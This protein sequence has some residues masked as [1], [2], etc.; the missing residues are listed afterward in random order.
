[1]SQLRFP[2]A[3]FPLLAALMFTPVA[4]WSAEVASAGSAGFYRIDPQT[5]EGLQQ[6]FKPI[7]QPL[8]FLSS[9]R[10]GAGKG[11]PENCIA[12]FE[13]TIRHTYSALEIDL[14]L[15]S[16]GTIVLNHDATLDRTTTGK[17]PVAA[18]TLAELKQLRL[19]DREGAVTD[20]Q[21]PTLDEAITWA[22]GKT[23]LIL[24][25]KDV[26]LEKR[27][28][29]VEEHKAESYVMLMLYSFKEIETCHAR[30]PKIM[31]EVMIGDMER[32]RGFD[33]TGVP[34][35]SVVAFIS[36]DPP[37]AT[38][39]YDEIHQRGASCMVGT[40][41]NLDRQI[42]AGRVDDPAALEQG[43]RELLK[44]GIDVIETD[45]PVEVGR[46]LSINASVPAA[47]KQFFHAP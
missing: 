32:L 35:Q 23:I 46:L 42:L 41:R 17:G 26:P 19:K 4:G 27:I 31:M 2:N 30:N 5:P 28:A 13:H 14:R 39:I 12:T 44:R 9:H 33:K 25:G 21:I 20:Y 3:M 15:T 18:H 29:K 6:V 34:W 10:G 7:G 11:Y 38:T 1:M 22:R 40:S 47:K 8:P 24:D 36:H 37:E 45:T 43:Y 16:D